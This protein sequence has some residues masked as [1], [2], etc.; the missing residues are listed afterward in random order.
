MEQQDESLS[1]KPIS[2]PPVLAPPRWEDF[3]GFRETFLS[4]VTAPEDNAAC[5]AL[6]RM[7]YHLVLEAAH[8]MP[9]PPEGWVRTQIR[10]AVADLRFLQGFL[11]FVGEEHRSTAIPPEEAALCRA[12][13]R[14]ARSLR[15]IADAIEGRLGPA[16][17]GT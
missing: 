12:A 2:R 10:A 14:N 7:L 3:E 5:R 9:V 6:A 11:A 8:V 17:T 13:T 16:A 4:H 1:F 15:R